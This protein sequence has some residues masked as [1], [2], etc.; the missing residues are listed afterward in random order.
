MMD[1]LLIKG[2]ANDLV[3]RVDAI[4]TTITTMIAVVMIAAATM[5]VA[6]NTAVMTD[7]V[8]AIDVTTNKDT[9]VTKGV[10]DAIITMMTGSAKAITL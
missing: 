2:E 9:P 10:A 5:T 3:I 7:H 8:T 4:R 1:N 6:R